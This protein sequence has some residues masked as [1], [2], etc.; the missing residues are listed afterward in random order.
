MPVKA[1]NK[2]GVAPLSEAAAGIVYAAENGA[3]VI[4]NSWGCGFC[5][6]SPANEAAVEL[7]HGLG[8]VVVFSAGNSG[9][10]SRT[11]SPQNMHNPKPVVVAASN[12]DDLPTF[13]TN[14]GAVIDVAAPGGGY[15]STERNILSLRLSPCPKCPKRSRVDGRYLRLQGTS[16][17]APHASG[18]VALVLA[19]R[20]ILKNDEVR[21]VLEASSEDIDLPGF[22]LKT[23]AGRINARR[24]LNIA[25]TLEVKI[26]KPFHLATVRK[27]VTI[28][29]TV[30]GS[31]LNEYQLF[32]STEQ[33]DE[34]W[35]PIGGPMTAP[36]KGWNPWNVAIQHASFWMEIAQTYGNEPQ[37]PEI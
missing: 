35:R 28:R 2:Q 22:D 21:Q 9:L 12:Q 11:I 30:T 8:A 36:V 32:Y 19:H 27:S 23:G 24:A 13:F 14:F 15:D 20:P 29:G 7:A 4:N 16:M 31:D 17:S 37:R 33:P 26:E 34:N 1:F 6:S 5:P 18:A 3:D 25:S 10:D